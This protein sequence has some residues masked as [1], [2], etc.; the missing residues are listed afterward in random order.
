[1]VETYIVTPNY[2]GIKF[3]KNYFDSLFNQTYQNFKII[4]VDNSTNND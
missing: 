2:N 1:M 4:F 3:L